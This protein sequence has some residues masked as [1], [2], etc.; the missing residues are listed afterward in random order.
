M[1]RPGVDAKASLA[2][3]LRDKV[4]VEDLEE[5]AEAL[6]EFLLPLKQHRRWARHHDLADLLAHQ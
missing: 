6:L 3:N 4:F 1:G 5:Q 2:A